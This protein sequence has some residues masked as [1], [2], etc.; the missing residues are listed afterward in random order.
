MAVLSFVFDFMAIS[1]F[2]SV[3]TAAVVPMQDNCNMMQNTIMNPN[4][5]F[6]S[7]VPLHAKFPFDKAGLH[8][9]YHTIHTTENLIYLLQVSCTMLCKTMTK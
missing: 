3:E 4:K 7:V 2:L 6:V 1:S 8:E 5:V 9:L